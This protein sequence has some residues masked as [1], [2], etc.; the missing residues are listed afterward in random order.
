MLEYIN[1]CLE[2][3]LSPI[4]T[5]PTNLLT[6]I[7]FMTNIENQTIQPIVNL[8]PPIYYQQPFI[9]NPLISESYVIE[10]NKLSFFI[11]E[12]PQTSQNEKNL[13]SQTK[14]STKTLREQINERIQQNKQR[15]SHVPESSISPLKIRSKSPIL[16]KTG[17]TPQKQESSENKENYMPTIHRKQFSQI[18]ENIE[19]PK[20]GYLPFQNTKFNKTPSRQSQVQSKIKQELQP[21]QQQ[22]HSLKRELKNGVSH[23][24]ITLYK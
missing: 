12:S 17:H 10:E 1:R 14:Q 6:N 13:N 21:S 2:F 9:Q 20:K 19:T 11:S 8:N 15:Q 24:K 18:N 22:R 23:I 4:P 7:K 5:F 16:F 3:S